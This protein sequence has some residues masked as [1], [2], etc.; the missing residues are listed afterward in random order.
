MKI[1]LLLVLLTVLFSCQNRDTEIDHLSKGKDIDKK[2]FQM[3]QMSEMAILMEQMYVDNHRLKKQIIAGETLGD[4]PKH[5]EKI[6]TALLTDDSDRDAFFDFQA[7]EFL[8]AY[9]MIFDDQE[10]SKSNFNKA[11]SSCISCHEVKCGGPI[12]KIKKLLISE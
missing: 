1:H 5:F 9:Q 2:D 3:Y 4:F 6:H 8:K 10:H 7:K 12:P 11:I